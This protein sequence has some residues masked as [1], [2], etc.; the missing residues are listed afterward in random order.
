MFACSYL[1]CLTA[2]DRSARQATILLI[3]L[4]KIERTN[5]RVVPMNGHVTL[6]AAAI[7]LAAG[8]L[9][10]CRPNPNPQPT[11]APIPAPKPRPN[12]SQPTAPPVPAP[13]PN[14]QPGVGGSPQAQIVT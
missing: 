11:P 6:R 8:I 13:N 14:G 12:P 10:G 3:Q 7:V 5:P 2:G 9:V 4:P 1:T